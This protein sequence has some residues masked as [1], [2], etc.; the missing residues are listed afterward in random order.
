MSGSLIKKQ[1]QYHNMYIL[2]NEVKL[3]C[4]YSLYKPIPDISRKCGIYFQN[5]KVT[6]VLR[7]EGNSGED[8]AQRSP[9]TFDQVP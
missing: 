1:T 6:E 4:S 3:F 2:E 9:N 5:Q 8:L 7:F